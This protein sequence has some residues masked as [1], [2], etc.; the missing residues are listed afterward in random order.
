MKRFF[1][2]RLA[3]TSNIFLYIL[4]DLS[5]G[6]GHKYPGVLKHVIVA[7]GTPYGTF[8]HEKTVAKS[9]SHQK[10]FHQKNVQKESN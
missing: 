9:S 1:M 8:K 5:S 4:G 3:M 10:I 6:A 7:P 2:K